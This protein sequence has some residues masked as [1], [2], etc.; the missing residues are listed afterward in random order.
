M[1]RPE[2][3]GNGGGYDKH[4]PMTRKEKLARIKLRLEIDYYNW[5]EIKEKI[6]LA[7]GNQFSDIE[8]GLGEIGI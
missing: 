3:N 6:A 4:A 7:F 2:D 5:P 1:Y 8:R